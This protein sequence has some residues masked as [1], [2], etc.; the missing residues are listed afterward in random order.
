M[1]RELRSKHLLGGLLS[2][3]GNGFVHLTFVKVMQA[4]T[5]CLMTCLWYP[6]LLESRGRDVQ[7]GEKI[8][9]LAVSIDNV[10]HLR[11]NQ[12]KGT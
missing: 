9:L 12:R 6:H 7:M 2:K 10:E 4:W 11:S 5:G 8:K 3:V 1:I